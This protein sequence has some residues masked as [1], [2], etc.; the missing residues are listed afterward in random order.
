MTPTNLLKDW[1]DE[2]AA[3]LHRAIFVAEHRLAE[4]GLFSD[5][6]LVRTLEAHPRRDLGVNTMG[7][8]PARRQDW[9][10]GTADD[11]D[12]RTLLEVAKRG[13]LWLNLRRVIDHHREYREIVNRLYDE[14]ETRCD[15]GPISGRSANLLISAPEAIV[16]YHVDC[17]ANMLWHVRGTKRV[18]AYPLESGIVSAVTIEA[19]LCG[20][21]S[22]EIEYRREMDEHAV[23][24]DLE[25]G[26]MITWPQHTPH[27]VENTGGLNVSLSTEHMTRRTLR[28]NNVYLANRHFRQLLGGGFAST[29]I[30]GFVPALK[31]F[32]IRAARR[33]PPIAPEPPRGFKYPVTFQV[34]PDSPGGVR[35]IGAE[36][37]APPSTADPAL[38]K[39]ASRVPA[40]MPIVIPMTDVPG[41]NVPTI[42]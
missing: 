35:A 39:N 8:D 38:G 10:E 32:A 13:R 1:T 40:T 42:R 9:Q 36:P 14:L 22:E 21:K 2:Q 20:E 34:D 31:E 4:L 11:L 26:Q 37:A 25:P 27:R 17:P 3:Q 24:V 33:L 7:S 18:W 28:K 16:Y 30:D 5:D 15:C 41:S 19:V 12:G 29:E 23:V 6:G